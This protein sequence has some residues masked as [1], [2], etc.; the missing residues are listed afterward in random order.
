[1]QVRSYVLK[2]PPVR[3]T[4]YA[5]M[6]PREYTMLENERGKP[7]ICRHLVSLPWKHKAISFHKCHGRPCYNVMVNYFVANDSP[8]ANSDRYS[9]N[10][11]TTN[12]PSSQ[13]KM[14]HLKRLRSIHLLIMKLRSITMDSCCV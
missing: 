2:L 9:I 13:I 14:S 6:R 5:V 10:T 3:C 11:I 8:S 1:M 4:L 12:Q 7:C